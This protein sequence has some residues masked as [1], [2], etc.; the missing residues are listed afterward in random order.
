MFV[1]PDGKVIDAGATEDPV[2]T[3]TLDL[4]AGTWTMVDANGQD[5]H[6][7]AMYQP[8]KILKTG[9]AADSG[10]AG[11]ATA[12]AYVLDA[13]Q[14]DARVAA[15]GVDAYRRAFQNT[16][17]LPDGTVLVTGAARHSTGRHEQGGARSGTV[18]AG[19][20]DVADAGSAAIPRLYH[21]TALLLPDGR[22]LMAGSGNDGPAV[23]QMQA[24]LF[25]PPYLFK[26][27]GRRS[28][29]RLM[30]FQ[31]G[32]TFTV[33]TADAASIASVS[34]IRPARSPHSFDEDQ[35]F[36]SL[37]FIPGSGCCRSRRRPTRTSRPPA[38]T[39][40]FSSTTRR[41]RGRPVRAVCGARRG[42]DAADSPD[43]PHG[44]RRSRF[45]T[46]S[47]TASTDNTGVALYNVIARRRQVFSPPH[48]TASHN[49]RRRAVVDT[50]VTAGTYYYV[51]TA[52]DVGGNVSTASNEAAVM[53]L[54]DT[55]PPTVAITAPA[56][57]PPSPAQSR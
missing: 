39:C 1:L 46:L 53:V 3:S 57:A 29:A 8:G 15:G 42:H 35:R 45:A 37:S 30:W 51:V 17:L 36:L 5:G 56:N 19:H 10:T 12:T 18:V 27:R 14:T 32:S 20:R 40:C 38:T 24:E 26:A 41:S 31:Y 50:A 43:G 55:T 34:L 25:S 4:T 11:N 2:A 7:A 49:A 54:A 48:R 44:Q 22:V 23:N 13:T 9:T 21:S 6:S 52:Q 16:T 47:W 33:T 28:P